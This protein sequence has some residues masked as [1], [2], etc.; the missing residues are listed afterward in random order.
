MKNIH[1][2]LFNLLREKKPLALATIIET[3]GSTPQVVGASA[4]FFPE[5]LLAGTVGG[6]L[7]EADT[8][9][10]AVQA[11]KTRTSK[12]FE[13]YLEADI[14][15]EE[16]AICGGKARVFIDAFPE[17]HTDTYE[18][19]HQSVL[20]R[21]PGMLATFINVH[22]DEKI[23]VLRFWIDNKEI[24]QALPESPLSFFQDEVRNAF[25]E[26]KP[27]LLRIKKKIFP[28]E[29]KESS[30]FL[31]P[32][33]PLPQLVIAGAGHIGQAVAHLGSLLDFEVAVIDDRPEFAN[34]ER[35]P[36]TDYIIVDEI[37]RA[38]K[39]FPVSSDTYIVIVTRGHRYDGEALR[40]CIASDAA[41]IGMIGSTRKI[42]LMRK[43]FL[44]Q[45]WASPQQF[46]RVYAPIG[47]DINSK[48][49][50]EIA[51]SITAQLVL[52]R[53]KI[54]DKRILQ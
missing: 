29:I 3:K 2:K 41:Y 28:H 24:A 51:V 26:R 8:K 39:N 49:V 34:K 22:S 36:D 21:K 1:A 5:G 43:E 42:K 32:I 48:T 9:K 30:L 14:S 12:I 15:S 46:D 25:M 11:A 33:F 37:A 10:K 47:I 7:L 13:F 16:G 18:K 31:E 20:Q 38:I 17:K 35:L 19:L 4:I 27:S 53:S 40:E 54:Q 44:E 50:E 23:S 45:G 6:G 52:I